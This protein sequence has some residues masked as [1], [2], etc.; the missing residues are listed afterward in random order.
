MSLS[1]LNRLERVLHLWICNET[2]DVTWRNIL[3][4]MQ[5]LKRKDKIRKVINYLEKPEIY[6]KY[7]HMNNFSP[8]MF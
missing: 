7:I 3:K 5:A 6:R 4:V 8:F 1:N 2:T